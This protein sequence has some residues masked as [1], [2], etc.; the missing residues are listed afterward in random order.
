MPRCARLCIDRGAGPDIVTDVGDGNDQAKSVR[1][2]LRIDGIVEVPCV[3]AIDRDERQLPEVLAS[4]CLARVDVIAPGLRLTQRIGRKLVRQIEARNRGF[5]GELDR[6]VRI[7]P[8]L[9]AG[10]RR[11]RRARVSRDAGDDPI[12][13]ARAVQCVVRDRTSQLQAPIRGVDPCCASMHLD[14]TEEGVHA[15]LDHLLDGAQPAVAGVA[16]KAHA[17]PIAVHDPAHLGRGQ[18]D[19][20]LHSLDAQKAVSGPVSAHL[21]LDH[22]AGMGPGGGSAVRARHPARAAALPRLLGPAVATLLRG[23]LRLPA[24]RVAPVAVPAGRSYAALRGP[25]LGMGPRLAVAAPKLA[26]TRFQL[27]APDPLRRLRAPAMGI[28]VVL[29]G[30]RNW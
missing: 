24:T 25:R 16:R 27:T 9:D 26:S 22:T 4:R 2:R 28:P 21:A 17:Q 20:V 10:L 30:W 8:L 1:M 5:R 19:A 6:A 12:A 23:R 18:E 11:A 3:L 15:M 14:G 29:P 7:E 13:I